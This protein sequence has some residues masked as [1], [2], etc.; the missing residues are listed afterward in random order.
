MAL[1]FTFKEF[2]EEIIAIE[3][4]VASYTARESVG[5]LQRLK[6]ALNNVRAQ[7][8]EAVARWEVPQAEPFRTIVSR[9]A[10]E[11]DEGGQDNISAEISSVW[12]IAPFGNRERG[13]YS[14]YFR[15]A[16]IASTRV[17]LIRHTPD[18]TEEV[19]MWR[20]EIGDDDAPGCRFHVQV[21][22][23]R[24]EVPFPHSISIPRLPSI[25]I[26]PMAVIEFVVG[27]LFQD[28]WPQ[29]AARMSAQMNRWRSIQKERF[30]RL[31]T[32]QR[33]AVESST[34]SPWLS[35]KKAPI[36]PDLFMQ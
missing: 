30:S 16:G 34:G 31:L 21:L 17:R 27:E 6:I 25:M 3:A 12:E 22:G 26:S 36:A 20:M 8:S 9:G 2:E 24:M 4:L 5:V 19:G 1:R 28:Q 29:D 7:R 23:E 18:I 15:I 32:W 33:D 10:Y 13:G 11:P 35:L 14:R